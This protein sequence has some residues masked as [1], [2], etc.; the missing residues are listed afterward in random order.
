MPRN[1]TI[2]LMLILFDL[3]H[4]QSQIHPVDTGS[5]GLASPA[6]LKYNHFG[7]KEKFDE[8]TGYEDVPNSSH[9]IPQSQLSKI[10]SQDGTKLCQTFCSTNLVETEYC[11]QNE[12][13]NC[14]TLPDEKRISPVSMLTYRDN[15]GLEPIDSISSMIESE[16]KE[17]YTILDKIS[18]TPGE[19]LFFSESCIPFDQFVKRVYQSYKDKDP[20]ITQYKALRQFFDVFEG[21]YAKAKSDPKSTEA[22]TVTKCEDCSK[23]LE[24]FKKNFDIKADIKNIHQALKTP[25]FKKFLFSMLFEETVSNNPNCKEISLT[26]K[27]SFEHYPRMDLSKDAKP[28]TMNEGIAVLKQ[29]IAEGKPVSISGIC[30]AQDEISKRCS[31]HCVVM[32]GTK[33]VKN[34]STGEVVELVQV[35]NSWGKE[36]QD[37][38]NGGWIKLE[39]LK[40]LIVTSDDRKIANSAN[41]RTQLFA[42]T[43]SWSK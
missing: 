9:I 31:T 38:T 14:N 41:E 27:I 2:L 40:G 34:K 16:N 25:N 24:L 37:D 18:S 30:Y 10:K 29:K 20:S 7:E 12:I 1:M 5:E 23:L 11:K 13:V 42:N 8:S 33:K 3:S 21:T 43:F 26:K 35:Q 15:P 19:P 28:T 36:W 4:V 39:V 22:T 17:I 6:K 32:T